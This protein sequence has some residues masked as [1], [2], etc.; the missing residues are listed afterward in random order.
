MSFE[1]RPPQ[2]E[3]RSE[4]I[5][6]YNK[7]KRRILVSAPT[8]FG[9]TILA[10]SICAGAKS[11]N[12]RV[13]FTA[14]RITLAEQTFKKFADLSPSFLQG[15]SDGYNHEALIQVATLQTLSSRNYEIEAPEIIIIDEVHYA[16]ESALIQGLFE[17]FP[18]ALVIGL[19]ATPVD[20]QG[21]LL[22][23]F[24][25]IVDK[26]QTG[27]LIKLGWLVPFTVYSPIA[28]DLSQVK[29]VAGEYEEFGVISAIEKGNITA[30]AVDNYIKYGEGRKFIGFAVNQAHAQEIH[31]EFTK[32]GIKTGVIISSTTPDERNMLLQ[33]F[34]NGLIQGLISVEILTTG[35]D[36]PT[37]RLVILF[38][39]TKSW[40]KFIQCCG[41]GI[42]LLGDTYEESVANGKSDCILLDCA[43]AVEEHGMPDTRKVFKF[44][45]R[46]GK[47]LDK[48]LSVDVIDGHDKVAELPEIKRVYLKKISSLLDLYENK[49]YDKEADLQEDINKFLDRTGLFQ[50]RQN[51][52][53]AFMPVSP[54]SKDGRWV[55]FT[56]KHGLPDNAVWLRLSSLYFGMELK[57]SKGTLTPYQKETLPEMV[58]HRVLFFIIENVMDAYYAIEHIEANIVVSDEG[59][60]VKN[61]IYELSERQLKLRE[62]LKI[63]KY[64]LI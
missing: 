20:S 26:Y 13:L 18:D 35:F 1:L 4:T 48:E 45:K 25:G 44:K 61:S 64:V 28:P 51:S 3:V 53:K 47:V 58:Q 43:G 22:E 40:K 32:R 15:D 17:K 54:G 38:A 41:R 46:I 31:D 59:L 63:P 23:G 11:R 55:H 49:V 56:N 19:S 24:D 30:S 39:P 29:V 8:G 6:L 34:K 27:D 33:R 10:H 16:Y 9:K 36:D 2:T 52:G 50:Y 42:R 7:G 60:L 14:H 37:V 62:R 5:R 12:K 21:Y 57:L